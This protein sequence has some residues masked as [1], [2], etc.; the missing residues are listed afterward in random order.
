MMID[1]IFGSD[2]LELETQGNHIISNGS[3]DNN[4]DEQRGG[5]L[6]LRMAR[7]SSKGVFKIRAYF[8]FHEE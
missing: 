7:V 2:Y 6:N 4:T 8:L 3:S 5:N 1:C